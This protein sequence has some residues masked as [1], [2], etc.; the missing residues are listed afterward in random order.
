[1]KLGCSI[2]EQEISQP[3]DISFEI[4]FHPS[5]DA[6]RTDQIEDTFCYGKI[7]EELRALYDGKRI[8]T[9]EKLAGLGYELIK[10]KVG[11]RGAV[12]L[13]VHKLKPPVEGLLDGVFFECGDLL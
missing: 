2:E 5:P 11:T 13:S 10:A 8:Q 6:C 9:V 1:V 7:A 4:R 3:V 12:K